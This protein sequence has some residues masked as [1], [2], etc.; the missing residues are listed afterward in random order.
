MANDIA[1]F[2]TLMD[3]G[4]SAV[5]DQNWPEA[6]EVYSQALS[7]N[8]DDPMGLASL[9]LAY[10][11]L[12][13]YEEALQTYQRLIILTPDDPM[14]YERISQIYEH[15]GMLNE[16]IKCYL[17]TAELQLKARDIDR[18]VDNYYDMIRLDPLNQAAHTRLAKIFDKMGRKDQAVTEFI[19]LAAILQNAGDPVKAMQ[20]ASL[21][22]Q[23]SPDSSEAR[24]AIAQL[25]SGSKLPL[26]ERK[27]GGTGPVR[28]AQVRGMEAAP[29]SSIP[30][31]N[32]DPF[33]EAKLAA[34]KEMAG[35]LFEQ[36]D[37]SH[38]SGRGSQ[39]SLHV[40]TRGTGEL[41]AEQSD[42]KRIQLH[43]SQAIDLQTS[44]QDD[45]SVVELERAIDLG[46]NQSAA[47]YL[48]GLLIKEQD[49]QKSMKYLQRSVRNPAYALASF[50]LIGQIYEQSGQLKEASINFL[51]ALRLADATTVPPNE[52]EEL[53]QLYDPIFE[54]SL[55]VSQDKDLLNLCDV[56][57]NQLMRTDWRAYLKAARA[58]LPPQ[59]AGSP[60]MPLAE[61][62][63][64]STSSQMVESLAL[65]KKLTSEGK[66]RTAMEEAFHAL[67][68]A[69]TYL[70]LHIQ[71]G[72]IL[73]TE[74]HIA[75]A[76]EKFLLISRLYTIR[77]ETAQAIRLLYR[78]TKLA[79]MD[80]S[81][82]NSLINLLKSI[83]RNDDAIQQYMELAHVHYTLGELDEA[84]TT[85]ANALSLSHQSSTARDWSVQILNKLADIELQSL[86][87]KEAIKVFEQLRS[88]QPLDSSTRSMLID[89]YLRLG[90]TPAALNELDAYLKLLDAENQSS[91]AEKFLDDLLKE[92]PDNSDLQ[93]RMAG[94]F[95]ARDDVSRAVEKLDALAERL[96]NE[97]NVQ[98][99]IST[100]N[101]II[102]LNPPN[103][104]DYEKLSNELKSRNLN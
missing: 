3:K 40:L 88:L 33:I 90:L 78:V 58:Q 93:K 20:V 81:V 77:G 70:P 89:L 50:L 75:E 86:N 51:Q 1:N 36:N 41:S 101:Q 65:V 22:Q 55:Q 16:A 52:A 14:P 99:A 11:Q 92:R 54:S 46:L 73:I 15:V 66:L 67:I 10:F 96:M 79:S 23:V 61:M 27:K 48:V 57:N 47:Y 53:M 30:E 45:R 98:G 62:L 8:P 9:G 32:Y 24:L 4:H 39:R 56:I 31:V 2:Q 37:D 18:A 34:L 13:K 103:R 87:W 38:S 85:Y 68:Y 83:G 28:M 72:E 63:M 100:V 35:L 26:P 69:P 5:W 49:P 59:P 84:R 7:E 25:K 17:Q 29:T 71:I 74:G 94:Y 60:P 104:A 19:A 97:E 102:A 43:L 12:K 76:V 91:A 42:R 64:E 82:R 95:I 80:F 21:A 44:G 6:A